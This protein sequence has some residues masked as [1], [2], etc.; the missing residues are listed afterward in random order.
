MQDATLKP[1]RRAPDCSEAEWA[2]RVELAALYRLCDHFQITDLIYTHLS[3]RVPGHADQ[4]LVNANGL[5]F[6]EVTASN[7]VKIDLAGKIIADPLGLGVLSGGY[8]IHGAVLQGRPDIVCVMHVHTEA[9]IA[10]SCQ[11][12]GLL[13]LSQHA[14]RFHNRIAYYDYHGIVESDEEC[15][16]LQEALGS[17]QILMLRNH[18]LLV[19]GR[20]IP[21]AFDLLHH[22]ERACRIQ[23]TLQAC[24]TKYTLAPPH[25]AE[26]VAQAYERLDESDRRDWPALLRLLQRAKAIYAV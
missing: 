2:R 20:S 11:E 24:G 18:G 16:G 26:Q 6:E 7:L 15:R 1:S 3:A 9:G 12:A 14:M 5:L 17:K 13:P 19:T 8:F 21:E 10:V 23:V 25:I 4:F 22:L